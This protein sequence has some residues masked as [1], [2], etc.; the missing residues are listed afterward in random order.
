MINIAKN[1][2]VR[3]VVNIQQPQGATGGV[4]PAAGWSAAKFAEQTKYRNLMLAY[5]LNN[6]NVVILDTFGM[7]VNPLSTTGDILS[8]S[9]TYDG[10]HPTNYAVYYGAKKLVTLLNPLIPI[11]DNGPVSQADSYGTNANSINAINNPLLVTATGGTAS[12]PHTGTVASGWTTS[13]NA[14]AAAVACSVVARADGYGNNQRL[15]ITPGAANDAVLMTGTD[16]TGR[17]ASGDRVFVEWE[18]TVTNPGTLR[19]IVGFWTMTFSSTTPTVRTGTPLVA[20]NEIVYPE[21]VTF[22]VRT[23][24][25]LITGTP[26]GT[27]IPLLNFIFTGASSAVTIDVGRCQ[28]IKY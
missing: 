16:Y 24:P 1:A 25:L 7:T 27:A 28:I 3:V 21:N 8:T 23:P 11:I 15:V 20:A 9:W 10:V 18:V 17:F 6:P 13:N 26:S 14:G 22:K 19:N 4:S 5:G 12:A 2:G